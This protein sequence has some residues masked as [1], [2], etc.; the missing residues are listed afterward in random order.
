MGGPGQGDG[1]ERPYGDDNQPMD[2][3]KEKVSPRRSGTKTVGSF[4]VD[5]VKLDDGKQ[6]DL[7]EAAAAEGAREA[8]ALDK[9]RIPP[10]EKRF[11]KDYFD[12]L[13]PGKDGAAGKD[14]P[15]APPKEAP[16]K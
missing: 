1:G 5:G 8:E 15:S 2:T 7:A 3:K 6:K 12:S 10:A 16:K 9:A 4:F 13:T 11:V 14:A